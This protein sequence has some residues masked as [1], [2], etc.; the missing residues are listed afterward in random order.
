MTGWLA[1]ALCAPSAWAQAADGTLTGFVFEASTGAPVPAAKIRVGDQSAVSGPNGGFRIALPEGTYPVQIEALSYVG[2]DLTRVDVASAKVTELLITL[3][4]D[5]APSV[6]LEQPDLTEPS[7]GPDPDAGAPGTLRGVVT[8]AATGEPV[9]EARVFVRGTAA[10]ATTDANGRFELTLPPGVHGVSIL[11]NGYTTAEPAD[12]EVT[13]DRIT[14]LP[15]ALQPARMQLADFTISAP[16]IQG[17]TAGLLDERKESSAVAD[18]LGAEEMSRS[19]DSNAAAA[20]SRVTGLTVVDGKY[21]FVRGLGDRYSSSLLNGSVLPS[22]EPERRVVPLDLFPSSVLDSVVIQKTY[23]PD[24]P[25]EFGGGVIQLRTIRPP[26]EWVAEIGVSGGYRHGTTFTQGLDYPGGPSDWLG[27]DGG[28]RALPAVV[29]DASNDSPLE[30]GDLFSDSGYSPGELETFGTA[31]SNVWSPEARTLPPDGGLDLTLGHGGQ[32]GVVKAGALAALTYGNS[33]RSLGFQRNYYIAGSGGDL[34][35]QN[36]Y[37][38]DQATHEVQLGA[39]LTGG[40]EVGNQ[41]LRY[42]GMLNR[43]TDDTARVYSGFNRDVGGEIEITRLRWVERQ[44]AYH[45]LLGEHDLFGKAQL[46]WRGVY[47]TAGRLE[48]DRREYRYDL[49]DSTGEW[50]LSDRPEGN[51]RFFSDASDVTQEAGLD[52]SIPLRPSNPDDGGQLRAGAVAVTRDRAVDTRRFKFF[53]KGPISR[54]IDVLLERPEQVFTPDNIGSDGFQFEEF[55]RATDNYTA[56]QRIQAAYGMAELPFT[57]WLRAMAGAR[58]EHSAQRVQ[59][60][61]LFNPDGDPVEAN[62]DTTDL[63]PAATATLAPVDTVQLRAGFARTVS[64]PDFRE[65][66]PATF[67]DVTGGRL[68]FGNPELT[69]ARI[70]HYDLRL[71]FFPSAGEV[72]SISAFTK[73]FTDPVEVVVVASAQLSVTWENAAGASNSGIELEYRKDLP[74]NLFSAGNVA[75]IRSRVELGDNAGIQTSDERALQGQSPYVVNLQLGWDHPDRDHRLTAL[76]NV[77]GRRIVEVG[78]LGAPD[79]YELPVHQLDV[80]GRVDLGRGLAASVNSTNL[81]NPAAVTLQGDQVVDEITSG[82]AVGVGLKWATP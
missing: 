68:T 65:L 27:I 51:G 22:P 63:L 6:D 62:L 36:T 24:M 71:E 44:L 43:S 10:N 23:S 18:V 34:E 1:L 39:F 49:E 16:Y 29:A 64:R 11:R 8:A 60:F 76:Y 38:F 53:H 72:L 66:S 26:T 46:D 3:S 5:A 52:L 67:N 20:L 74:L 70:D 41:S 82:W 54:D 25:G 59:T 47:A 48:P 79:T 35:P 28:F 7:F 4:R 13:S 77:I 81:L 17:S 40:V 50:F 30:E 37:T 45:Q 14:E 75:L 32:A 19:G 21:V 57:P 78:A 80:V 31:M 55:T 61:E 56:S 33:W 42:T 15:V 58:L 73:Q 2:G 69:R 9:S 12:I